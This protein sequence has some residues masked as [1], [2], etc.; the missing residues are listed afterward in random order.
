MQ[1]F[2]LD[3]I[4]QPPNLHIYTQLCVCFSVANDSDATRQA[5]A[6]T[7]AQGLKKLAQRVPWLSG[8]IIHEPSSEAG[9][10]GVYK[11]VPWANAPPLVIRD[12]RGGPSAPTMEALQRGNF[13]M[14][15]LDEALIAP[16]MTIPGGTAGSK[17][18]DPTAVFAAQMSHIDGGMLL[19]FVTQHQVM[20]LA[21]QIQIMRLLSMVCR[22]EDIP[23]SEAELANSDRSDI[24]PPL[25]DDEP[26]PIEQLSRQTVKPSPPPS[27]P[28]DTATV[29]SVWASF[30]FSRES[31]AALKAAAL[32]T[33]TSPKVS[34]D[35]ALTAFIWQSITRARNHRLQNDQDPNTPKAEVTL[36]RAVDSR[37]YLGIP[38]EYPGLCNN[39]VYLTHPV[40]ETI[41]M[42]LG[43]MASEL[44]IAVDPAMSQIGLYTRALV[45]LLRRTP[46][47]GVVSMGANISPSRDFM[48]S[49]WAGADCY[50]LDFGM[51]MGTP[52]AVRRPRFYPVEGLGYLLPRHP[53]GEIV[54]AICLREGDMAVLR[55]DGKF[56]RYAVYVG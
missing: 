32:E 41:D 23:D 10:S 49:S 33:G 52:V 24:V 37:R 55:G 20:D 26:E 19:T 47:K 28:T 53:S 1:S 40:Q 39:M 51:G 54:L 21:G 5:A 45:A 46:D 56:G 12:L 27:A 8:K 7:L 11:I 34:T 9:N 38:K 31:L 3:I 29:V 13:P 18:D 48:L 4:G 17:P 35:D 36:G 42:P 22:G 43:K 50:G 44:R 6:D 15:L 2:N 14:Q 30:S 16:Y 25:G